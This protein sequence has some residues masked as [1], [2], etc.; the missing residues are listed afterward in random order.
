VA[1]GMILQNHRQLPGSIFGVKIV[2]LGFLFK[3]VV[4]APTFKTILSLGSLKRVTGRTKQQKIVKNYQRMYRK[5]L[6]I[7]NVF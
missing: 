1:S 3:G 6:F 4:A 2:A 7:L 5:Y